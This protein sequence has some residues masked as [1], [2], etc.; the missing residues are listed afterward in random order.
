M[1]KKPQKHFKEKCFTVRAKNLAAARFSR[2][3][4]RR[5]CQALRCLVEGLT[6]RRMARSVWAVA[7]PHYIWAARRPKWVV[8]TAQTGGSCP[9]SFF[10]LEFCNPVLSDALP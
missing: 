10:S 9:R 4:T 5:K 3:N 8:A 6:T 7:T 2:C 1:G